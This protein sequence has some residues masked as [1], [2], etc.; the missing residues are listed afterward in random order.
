MLLR[1]LR[2]SMMTLF[3][4]CYERTVD[5]M[6]EYDS[7]HHS[8]FQLSC[9]EGC[10]WCRAPDR[11]RSCLKRMAGAFLASS[12]NLEC[13]WQLYWQFQ[14][15]SSSSKGTACHQWGKSCWCTVAEQKLSAT[16]DHCKRTRGALVKYHSCSEPLSD[17]DWV[18]IICWVLPES[19]SEGL[20]KDIKK[21]SA[22]V[23]KLATLN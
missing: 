14:D 13:L 2:R 22:I 12:L 1:N 21:K 7:C 10:R 18:D 5:W 23:A 8:C 15:Y 3:L 16:E 17:E 11:W 19:K 20:V 4:H 9:K 6:P